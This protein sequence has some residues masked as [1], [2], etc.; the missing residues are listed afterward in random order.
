MWNAAFAASGMPAVYVP[1]DVIPEQLEAFLAACRGMP[2]LLGVSV[3]VPY[4]ERAAAAVDALDADAAGVGAVNTILRTPEGTLLG[5][6]TDGKAAYQTLEADL[7]IGPR[8]DGFRLLLLGAGGAARA[9]AA[10]VAARAP[11]AE[12]LV[13][14][15]RADRGAACVEA[16]RRMGGRAALVGDGVLEAILAD[17]EVVVNATPVGMTGPQ[18]TEGGTTW[19][20]PFSALA[21]APAPVHSPPGGALGAVVEGEGAMPVAPPPEWWPRAWPAIVTNLE[22]SLRRALRLRMGAGM[23]DLVYAPSE[24]VALKHVRWTGHR[25]ANGSRMLLLQAVEAFLL[26]SRPLLQHRPLASA[27]T[28]A[29]AMAAA[30]T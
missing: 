24:T 26:L 2:T 6:N 25:G 13:T 8:T 16:V 4:K 11:R 17:V 22:I 14:T 28:V 29:A 30:L 9:V 20:E 7:G 5:A 15:R 1:F 21:G 10:A 3:T 18:R 23:L 12:I 19:L 27:T